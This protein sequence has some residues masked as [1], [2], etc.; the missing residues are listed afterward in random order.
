MVNGYRIVTG[1]LKI[2]NAKLKIGEASRE[3]REENRRA[4][5]P[6]PHPHLIFATDETRINE[7]ARNRLQCSIRNSLAMP[8][9]LIL[10]TMPHQC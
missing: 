10:K 5:H 4:N 3:G 9:E 2:K 1:Q 6:H 8:L 7:S